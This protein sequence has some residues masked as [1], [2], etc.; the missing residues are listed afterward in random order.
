MTQIRLNRGITSNIPQSVEILGTQGISALKDVTITS[1]SGDQ[2]LIYNASTN[3]FENVDI[4]AVQ[5]NITEIDGGT[6]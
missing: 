3:Q 1:V 6:Y 2:I 5:D 4:S